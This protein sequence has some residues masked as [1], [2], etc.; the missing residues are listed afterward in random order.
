[1]GIMTNQSPLFRLLPLYMVIF[2]GFVGYSL[3]ITVFTPMILQN[4]IGMV[5]PNS[6]TSYRVIILGILLSVYPLGQF[7]ASSIMGAL[8]DRFGRKPMML[9][10]LCFSTACYILIALSIAMHNLWL[11]M[12]FSLLAGLFEANIA[13]AQS[14]IA[15]VTT[16]KMRTHYFGYIYL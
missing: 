7:F 13:I 2:M 4:T 14:A 9:I 3:M 5:P 12:I 11:L 16:E 1:M 15:D 10:T 6:T 8:S